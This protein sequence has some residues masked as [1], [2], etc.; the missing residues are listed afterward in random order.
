MKPAASKKKAAAAKPSK[1]TSKKLLEL[2]KQT[3]AAATEE[4]EVSGFP[5]PLDCLT[6]IYADP[7]A[8]RPLWFRDGVQAAVERNERAEGWGTYQT[9][10]AARP[11]AKVAG[12]ND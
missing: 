11:E 4:A 2:L 1:G 9:G 3:Q 8:E 6:G 12:G 10:S 7:P 5:E